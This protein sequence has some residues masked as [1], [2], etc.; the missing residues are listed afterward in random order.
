M[1]LIQCQISEF[2]SLPSSTNCRAGKCF[3]GGEPLDLA[4]DKLEIDHIVPKSKGGKDDENNYAPTCDYNRNKSS[5][6]KSTVDADDQFVYKL[7]RQ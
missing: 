2:S 3:I 1:V 5:S 7:F 6:A 4:K